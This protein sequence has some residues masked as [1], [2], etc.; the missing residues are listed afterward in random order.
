MIIDGLLETFCLPK[1]LSENRAIVE[2]LILHFSKKLK[3]LSNVLSF[4]KSGEGKNQT[5]INATCKKKAKPA[6][7]IFFLVLISCYLSFL[8]NLLFSFLLKKK[9]KEKE[10][11]TNGRGICAIGGGRTEAIEADILGEGQGRDATKAT[12][13]YGES[14]GGVPTNGADGIRGDIGSRDCG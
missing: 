5:S 13:V 6:P 14:V 9:E 4:K 8:S 3:R 11:L 10:N 1:D 7:K 2:G 12:A